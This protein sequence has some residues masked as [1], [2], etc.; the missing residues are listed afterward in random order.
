MSQQL[1]Y[2]KHGT[3]T[4]ALSPERLVA[5]HEPPVPYPSLRTAVRAALTQP[6]DDFP[7]FEQMFVPEDH[8][9]LAL[10]RYTPG[11]A[12]I[13]AEVWAALQ[14]RSIAAADTLILQPIGLPGPALG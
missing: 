8:V 10:D 3:F 5:F 14:S 6:L 4:C 9:T 12:E 2:G 7:S 11:A 13:I 1:Q